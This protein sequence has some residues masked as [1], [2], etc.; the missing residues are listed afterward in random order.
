ML[1]GSTFRN[2][3][4]LLIGNGGV[5]LRYIPRAT[6]ISFWTLLGTPIRL[7]ER[8]RFAQPVSK[9]ELDQDPV[10]IIGHWQAGHSFLHHLMCLD[11]QFAY[12]QLLHCALPS[13]FLSSRRL[14]SRFLKR[15]LP[16]TRGVDTLPL[17]IE[18]PQGDDF[19]LAGLTPYSFYHAYSF[20]KQA[21]RVFRRSVLFEDVSD[22]SVEKWKDSYQR[23]MSRVAVDMGRTRMLLRNASNTGRIRHI[24]T[25][26]PNARFIHVYRNPYDIFSA[27]HERW[28]SL[29]E[30]WALQK[31]EIEIMQDCSLRFFELMMKRYFEDKQ[32]ISP[33]RLSEVRYEDLYRDPV[34]TL[35]KVYD[36]LDLPGFADAEASFRRFVEEDRGTVGSASPL[37]IEQRQKVNRQWKFAFDQ[38]G[39]EVVHS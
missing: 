37:P 26:F 16:K 32:L 2:W 6:A 1:A 34:P 31:F 19:A 28:Q 17:G 5:D 24:L 18:E 13:A 30:R 22:L 7:Y 39:Y 15:K 38:W 10:F 23:L 29:L 9:V 11:T 12:V 27:L 20:P 14:A 4:R 25:M 3:C 8:V 33:E 21:E 35:Q 36:D